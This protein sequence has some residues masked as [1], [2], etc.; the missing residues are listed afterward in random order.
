MR[1]TCV[2]EIET[3]RGSGRKVQ[4]KNLLGPY[5]TKALMDA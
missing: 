4:G 3:S 2:I 1:G 5:F